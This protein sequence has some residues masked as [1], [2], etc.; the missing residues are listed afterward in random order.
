MIVSPYDSA[1]RSPHSQTTCL[2]VRANQETPGS[3]SRHNAP[4]LS[5]LNLDKS[6]IFA[7]SFLPCSKISLHF[8][9]E[10]P[11]KFDFLLSPDTPDWEQTL[12]RA[13]WIIHKYSQS[14]G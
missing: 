9:L 3:Q 7:Q 4:L 14:P 11:Y 13:Q 2:L 6:F 12:R 5:H 10:L 8:F 1:N